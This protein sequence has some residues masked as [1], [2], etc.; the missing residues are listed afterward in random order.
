MFQRAIIPL[1]IIIL[2]LI[3]S[4]VIIKPKVDFVENYLKIILFI[5][6]FC[7]IL[8]SQLTYKF[9]NYSLNFEI[10]FI[11]LPIIFI[12]IFYIILLMKTKFRLKYL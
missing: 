2:S 1:Y 8:F 11:L 3:S 9:I 5:S 4:L 10:L 12:F 6:G 7:I